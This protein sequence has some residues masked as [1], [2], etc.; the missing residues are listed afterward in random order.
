MDEIGDD[1]LTHQCERSSNDPL[2]ISTNSE[3]PVVP[4]KEPQAVVPEK[5]PQE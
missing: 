3:K 1:R 5:E 2:H 4:E